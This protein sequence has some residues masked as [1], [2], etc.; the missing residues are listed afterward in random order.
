MDYA[1]LGWRIANKQVSESKIRSTEQE[2]G[3]TFP[4]EFVTCATMYHGSA[5]RCCSFSFPEPK[6]NRSKSGLGR[7]LSFRESDMENI[8]RTFR[9][10]SSRLPKGLIPFAATGGGD[11]ICFDCSNKQATE[12]A[13]VYWVFDRQLVDCILPVAD[14]FSEFMMMLVEPFV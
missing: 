10:L 5:P 2:L 6:W 1:M 14:S 13:V 7:L 4:T 12:P 3:I 8:T 11:Y 9:R